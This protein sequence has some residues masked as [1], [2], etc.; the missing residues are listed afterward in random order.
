MTNRG[1]PKRF[2]FFL[3]DK[4]VKILKA[5]V[6]LNP[7]GFSAGE[8]LRQAIRRLF[9]HYLVQSNKKEPPATRLNGS[10][11][12]D[13]TP[14]IPEDPKPPTSDSGELQPPS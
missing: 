13:N 10:Q 4:E 6:E 12:H 7:G 9:T 2:N 14:D 8:L 5:A 11:Q 1:K 3:Y